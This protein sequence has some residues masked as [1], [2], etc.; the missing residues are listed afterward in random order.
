[1]IIVFDQLEAL[2][3]THN[4]NILLNFGEAVKEIFTHV[5]NSLIILNLFPERWQQF[6]EVFDG[7]I[8]DRIS[9]T[10]VRLERPNRRELKQ[11]L[12]R[13]L[14][15][16]ELNLELDSLFQSEAMNDI[17]EQPSIRAVI[18]RAADYYRYRV[19]GIPLPK[20]SVISPPHT[21]NLEQLRRMHTNSKSR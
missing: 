3:L 17:L 13:K 2:G 19:Q 21:N 12:E 8:V 11:I 16:L 5:P 6:R 15:T 20:P 18:N 7:S 4:H 10:T 9:Q 1:M 14:E